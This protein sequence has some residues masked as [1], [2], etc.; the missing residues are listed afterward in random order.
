MMKKKLVKPWGHEI[1]VSWFKHH[2]V[3]K[4]IYMTEG[5]K[6]SLQYHEEKSETNYIVSGKANVLK[7][8]K[9]MNGISEKDA[10]KIYNEVFR[11]LSK[12]S[13]SAW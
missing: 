10:L 11:V 3:L 8:I 2:H 9:V 4:R 13:I 12:Y 7:D 1:W 6:C 5:N